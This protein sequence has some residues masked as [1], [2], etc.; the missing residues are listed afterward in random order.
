MGTGAGDY[1]TPDNLNS[2]T[3]G[4]S[5]YWED[6]FRIVKITGGPLSE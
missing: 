2:G 5:V 6:G 1:V 4:L 3:L